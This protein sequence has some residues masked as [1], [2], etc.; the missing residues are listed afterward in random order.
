MTTSRFLDTVTWALNYCDEYTRSSEKFN[1]YD[2]LKGEQTPK[3]ELFSECVTFLNDI[4]VRIEQF[5]KEI[6]RI[7]L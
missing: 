3:Q 6:K 1:P 4:H 7:T 5:R 2:L